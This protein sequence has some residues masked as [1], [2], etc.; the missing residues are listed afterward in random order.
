MKEGK[1]SGNWKNAKNT[2]SMDLPV[3]FFEENKVQIAYIPMLDLSGYG[4]TEKEAMESL[5]EALDN[6]F[7]Y[8]TNKDTLVQDLKAH[9]WT[10]RKK[11]KPYVA[12]ELT[13]LITKNEYLHDIVNKR[14]Y[15]MDRINVTM[16]QYA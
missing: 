5:V 9:G 11:N 15:K 6:Y 14:P 16:P 13:D 2:V 3:M 10:I 8:T 1:L 4:K 12:P 7:S